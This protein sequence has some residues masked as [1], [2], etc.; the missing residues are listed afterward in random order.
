MKE[1]LASISRLVS[2]V[3]KR[4]GKEGPER[5]RFYRGL[6][7]P[8]A[9]T[10]LALGWLV[11]AAGARASALKNLASTKKDLE[12]AR[13]SA[14]DLSDLAQSKSILAALLAGRPDFEIASFIQACS[15]EAGISRASLVAI[16]P[17]GVQA[18]RQLSLSAE[19]VAIEM[20]SVSLEQLVKFLFQAEG[21][22]PY[23]VI[24]EIRISP[25]KEEGLSWD[26]EVRMAFL[27]FSEG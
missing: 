11:Y 1:R 19:N 17:S 3:R 15:S 10:L 8:F 2:R 14:K 18:T 27:F 26:V 5:G 12:N 4:Q 16:N 9:L 21:R 24:Q 23:P 7:I 20:R 25:G 6:L 22:N 13:L